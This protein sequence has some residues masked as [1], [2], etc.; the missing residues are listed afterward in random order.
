MVKHFVQEFKSKYNKDLATNKRAVRMLHNA[1][2]RAKRTLSCNLSTN[3]ELDSVFE[4]IDFYTSITRAKF[5]ELNADLFCSTINHVEKCFKDSRMD[6]NQIHDI[7]LVG[8]STRI[9]MVQK[10]LQD[11]FDEK[12][13]NKSINPE[14]AVAYGAAVQA[15]L[16]AGE[17]SDQIQ[18]LVLLDVNPLSLGTEVVGGIMSVI[19]KRNKTIPAT[20]TREYTTVCN[21]QT[22][23]SIPVYEGE[24]AMTKDNNF[25]G[26]CELMGI[27]LAP[28]GVPKVD[29]TFEIDANGILNVTAVEKA[30]GNTNKITITID[31]GRLIKEEIERM[32]EEAEKF[33]AEDERVQR[34]ITAQNA[35]QYY[36]FNMK[37]S[38]EKG[39]LKDKISECDKNTI[40]DKCNEVNRWLDANQNAEKEE[41]ETQQ[42]ELESVCNPITKIHTTVQSANS[43]GWL[44]PWNYV[45]SWYRSRTNNRESRLNKP[46]PE[47]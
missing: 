12:L 19:I 5:E 40:L 24:R 30:A 22:Y 33:R 8:G 31:K 14:E 46:D 39:E 1:C 26:E 9:P 16:L 34:R 25:L 23:V 3:I 4:G 32:L 6:K 2:E 17:L 15:A 45:S 29:V 47:M 35:L 21:N 42:K 10:L 43:S 44:R 20:S 38:V 7:V 41:F 11:F 36:C 37:S 28:A 18:G 27:P 13:L